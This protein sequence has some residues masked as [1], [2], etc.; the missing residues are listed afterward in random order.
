MVMDAY[1]RCTGREKADDVR[2]RPEIQ[3]AAINSLQTATCLLGHG[4]SIFKIQ[5]KIRPAQPSY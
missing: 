4:Q 5:E 1:L 3:P 2:R